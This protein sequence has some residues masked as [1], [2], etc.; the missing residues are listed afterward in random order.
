MRTT[1]SAFR[2]ILTVITA[3]CC[4]SMALAAAGSAQASTAHAS[5][6]DIPPVAASSLGVTVDRSGTIH[7]ANTLTSA[8]DL[9][10]ARTTTV[11][12]TR[13][14]GGGCHFA[15]S[16]SAPA[17]VSSSSY[18]EETAVNPATCR[19]TLVSGKLTSAGIAALDSSPATTDTVRSPTA[20][21]SS[22]AATPAVA[23]G[24]W[25]AFNKVSFV[26]P[27][28]ITI[29][30]LTDNLTWSGNGGPASG[31]GLITGGS[32]YAVSYEFPY[33]NWSASPFTF[34]WNGCIGCNSLTSQT[35][36]TFYN[37]DFEEI[38][39]QIFGVAGYEACGFNGNPATFYLSPATT[40][41]PNGYYGWGWSSNASGGCSDLVH[42]RQN[43]GGGSSS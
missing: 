27:L 4:A 40:G 7:F 42:F 35:A 21:G 32:A 18:T 33:D 28:D 19:E 14:R 31:N 37:S 5:P 6:K 17:R 16:S 25:A 20:P 39:V 1:H 38:I 9:A 34:S 30:S 29:T 23:A 2:R 41:Y 24:T 26:D 10:D 36:R 13:Q 43:N 11:K 15:S 12:G 8:R 3:G 22:H